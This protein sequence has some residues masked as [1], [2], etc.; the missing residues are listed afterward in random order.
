MLSLSLHTSNSVTSGLPFRQPTYKGRYSKRQFKLRLYV[1]STSVKFFQTNLGNRSLP[2]CTCLLQ[3]NAKSDHPAPAR[4]YAY[5]FCIF[6]VVS[7]QQNIGL[8]KNVARTPAVS[9][10]IL[11][12]T[13]PSASLRTIYLSIYSFT[14]TS[15]NPP[16]KNSLTGASR[17]VPRNL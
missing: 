8:T 7:K 5:H 1:R 12:V 13:S 15:T 10:S 16:R 17:P 11:L 4:S 3:Q 6:L 14:H 9:L 2:F